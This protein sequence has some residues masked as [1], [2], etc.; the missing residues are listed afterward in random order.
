M[1]QAASRPEGDWRSFVQKCEDTC[2]GDAC[3]EMCRAAG[4]KERHEA[5]A[6]VLHFD[7]AMTDE[8]MGAK[9]DVADSNTAVQG[10]PVL[11]PPLPK[12][13]HPPPKESL[14]RMGMDAAFSQGGS[15]AVEKAPTQELAQVPS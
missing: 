11:P 13:V 2:K 10:A 15:N 7:P 8:T 5:P 12:G 6:A 14:A 9:A 1:Q 3:R 4:A